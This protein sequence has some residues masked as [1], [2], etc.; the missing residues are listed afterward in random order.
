MKPEYVRHICRRDKKRNRKARAAICKMI[1]WARE[2]ILPNQKARYI[3]HLI[4]L[5]SSTF[6]KLPR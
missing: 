6:G 5:R 2:N 3:S 1:N 4:I